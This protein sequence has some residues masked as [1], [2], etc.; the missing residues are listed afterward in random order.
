MANHV[1]ACF[2]MKCHLWDTTNFMELQENFSTKFDHVLH[3]P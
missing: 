3:R 2:H 1:W